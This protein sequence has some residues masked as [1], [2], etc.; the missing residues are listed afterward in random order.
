MIPKLLM[1]LALAGL[2]FF[3][4]GRKQK[5]QAAQENRPRLTNGGKEKATPKTL[6]VVRTSPQ[7]R[8]QESILSF[9]A[10][11]PQGSRPAEVPTI[12]VLTETRQSIVGFGGAFTDAAC[13]MFNEMPREKREALFQDLF[14]HCGL[15]LNFCRTCIG[16]SDYAT[17]VYSYDEGEPDPELK[18]FSIE[19]DRKYILPI[20]REALA[21][22]PDIFLYGSAW[23]PPGW[24][25]S[26][27]SMLGG[28]MRRH[29]LEPYSL[30]LLKFVQAYGEEGVKIKAVTVQNEVD[31]DQDGNMPACIWAQELEVDFVRG[32]LGPLFQKEGIDTKIWIIDHNY[33]LWGRALGSLDTPGMLKYT[34][35]IAW[36]G[37]VGDASKVSTVHDS[38]PDVSMF[39]TEGGPDYTSA[40]YGTDWCKWSRTFSNILSNWCRGITVWNLALN[41]V[42]K[43]NIGP[44]PCGGLVTINSQTKE[45]SLSGQYFALAHYSKYVK[46][47]ARVLSTSQSSQESSL[48]RVAF[49]NPDGGKV[50]VVTNSGAATAVDLVEGGK[51]VRLDLPADSVTTLRW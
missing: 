14:G 11:Q 35:G 27:G 1:A 50:L 26:N 30:Y 22:N 12:T 51:Q 31:T 48:S 36:H 5:V 28:A 15:N 6:A 45:V 43:P 9:Q 34:D 46:P 16:A 7:A 33:N 17:H 3:L 40:D 29:S 24:M 41:E 49:L 13:F 23:S 32:F 2:I 19:H 20:I 47:G 25:K 18:R 44:F 37:Y 10:S 21:V 42:G 39:W 4:V 38:Y 8:M